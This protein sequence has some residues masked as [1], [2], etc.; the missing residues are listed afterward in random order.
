MA[1]AIMVE[2]GSTPRRVPQLKRRWV[3]LRP[4]KEVFSLGRQ[5]A[6]AR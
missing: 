1:R 5:A 3:F 6:Q 2:T 4:L